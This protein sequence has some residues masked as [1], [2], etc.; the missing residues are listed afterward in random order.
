MYG[1]KA[2]FLRLKRYI[3]ILG[4]PARYININI[5]MHTFTGRTELY[6]WQIIRI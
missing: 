6:S 2:H 3:M 4:L 5:I 1:R